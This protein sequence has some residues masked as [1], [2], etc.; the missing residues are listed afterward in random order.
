M[1]GSFKWIH[2][3]SRKVYCLVVPAACVGNRTG[4]GVIVLAEHSNKR[5]QFLLSDG[6]RRKEERKH[7]AKSLW[8]CHF[9]PGHCI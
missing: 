8:P 1:H 2:S 6:E 7:G 4:D 5:Q 3:T 9:R